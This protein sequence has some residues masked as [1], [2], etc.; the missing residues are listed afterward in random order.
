MNTP[1]TPEEATR[2]PITEDQTADLNHRFTYHA[3]TGS[4]PERFV[5]LREKAKELAFLIAQTTRPS[6]EQSVALERLE[7]SIFWANAA[8]AR[9][10]P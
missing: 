8:V 10:E 4:K 7:E 6:V 1:T 2:F 5:A 3:P 9:H